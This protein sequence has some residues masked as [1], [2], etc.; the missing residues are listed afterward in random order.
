MA[1]T[2]AFDAFSSLDGYGSTNEGWGKEGSELLKHRLASLRR[3][4]ADGFLGPTSIGSSFL[5]PPADPEGHG[6]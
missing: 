5:A 6:D 3:G 1:A 4:A 2:Y